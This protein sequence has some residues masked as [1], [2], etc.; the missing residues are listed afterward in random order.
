MDTYRLSPNPDKLGYP[1]WRFSRTT[2]E[3]WVRAVTSGQARSK[4]ANATMALSAPLG[5]SPWYDEAFA[6][7]VVDTARDD[8]PDHGVVTSGGQHL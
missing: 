8:V 1:R 4:V 6:R 3:V 5:R 7:C 2:K